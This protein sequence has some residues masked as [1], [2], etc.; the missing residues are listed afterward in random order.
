MQSMH[1]T[2]PISH[3]IERML[4][5]ALS[6]SLI[7]RPDELLWPLIGGNVWQL[8]LNLIRHVRR[9]QLLTVLLMLGGRSPLNRDRVLCNRLWSWRWSDFHI[10]I[11]LFD[12]FYKKFTDITTIE[13]S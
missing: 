9:R 3:L 2:I 5:L 11:V 8:G 13:A 6:D 1:S 10:G 7:R 4:I 12:F